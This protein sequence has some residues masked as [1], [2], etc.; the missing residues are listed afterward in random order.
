MSGLTERLRNWNTAAGDV[1]KMCFEA[2][3]EIDRLTGVE[4]EKDMIE[5]G[6]KCDSGIHKVFV[7]T[8]H[9]GDIVKTDRKKWLAIPLHYRNLQHSCHKLRRDAIASLN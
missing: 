6:E 7:D 1:A 5:V 8:K 9:V 4:M 2:A 3:D